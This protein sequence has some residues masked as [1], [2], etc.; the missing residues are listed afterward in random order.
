MLDLIL[1]SINSFVFLQ[2]TKK[3]QSKFVDYIH[4]GNTVTI[5]IKMCIFDSFSIANIFV[6]FRRK[7]SISQAP[8]FLETKHFCIRL[9]TFPYLYLSFSLCFVPRSDWLLLDLNLV[10]S[11]MILNVYK[12]I[13]FHFLSRIHKTFCCQHLLKNREG[14]YISC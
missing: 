3:N 12:P 5:P 14:F 1:N 11:I 10:S 4:R 8:S 13:I 7:H 2:N 9:K 6:E